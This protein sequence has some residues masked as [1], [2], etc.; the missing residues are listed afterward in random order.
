M[1]W[2]MLGARRVGGE[3]LGWVYLRRVYSGTY[4][5]LLLLYYFSIC[6]PYAYAHVNVYISSF[7]RNTY[8]DKAPLGD[9]S[10]RVL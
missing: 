1:A 3:Y 6:I 9:A 8:I 7:Q 2:T 4:S 5:L 10:P